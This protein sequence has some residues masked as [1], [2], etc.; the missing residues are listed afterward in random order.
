MSDFVHTY[1]SSHVNLGKN[2][3]RIELWKNLKVLYPQYFDKVKEE[4]EDEDEEND[5]E[6]VDFTLCHQ[7]TQLLNQIASGSSGREKKFKVLFIERMKFSVKENSVTDNT[8]AKFNVLEGKKETIR[9]GKILLFFQEENTQSI[10]CKLRWY[11]APKLI[12]KIFYETDLSETLSFISTE[13]IIGQA[14]LMK[15]EKTYICTKD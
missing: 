13:A 10:F 14:C 15:R 8:L 11:K 4:V 6:M 3:Q 5:E 1:K 9:F 7:D 2:I 12:D